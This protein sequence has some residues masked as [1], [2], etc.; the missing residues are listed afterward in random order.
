[1][2]KLSV[3]GVWGGVFNWIKDFL[4]RRKIQVRIGS[5]LPNQ[6]LVVNDT[7]QGT[8]ISP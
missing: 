1:M 4:F 2:I 5:E 6:C 8:V 3:I 7:P